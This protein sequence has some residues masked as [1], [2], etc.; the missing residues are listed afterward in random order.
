MKLIPRTA[1]KFGQIFL[2]VGTKIA[3]IICL[4]LELEFVS[5]LICYNA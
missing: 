3:M 1:V 5:N 2:D 4:M